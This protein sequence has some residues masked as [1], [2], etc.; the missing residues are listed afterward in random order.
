[1]GGHYQTSH[2]HGDRIVTAFNM[3]PNGKIDD[4]TNLYFVQTDNMG[5]MWCT[6]DG[7]PIDTPVTDPYCGALITGN[8]TKLL[9]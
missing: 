9:V 5:A 7:L 3:H 1:M 8:S 4:R 6:A 2:R